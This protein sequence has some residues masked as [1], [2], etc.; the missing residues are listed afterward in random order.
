MTGGFVNSK[1]RFYVYAGLRADFP[2]RTPWE[3]EHPVRARAS[4]APATG[5]F[6]LGGPVE[7]RSGIEVS[8]QVGDAGETGRIGLMLFHLSNAHIYVHNP[9]SESLVFTYQLRP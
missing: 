4:T 2:L 5:G 7:F 8:R 3:L 6:K 1:G 9:G